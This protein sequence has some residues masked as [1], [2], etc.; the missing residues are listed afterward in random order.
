MEE[1]RQ[2]MLVYQQVGRGRSAHAE[3]A[4]RSVH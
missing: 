2:G 3:E 4:D 1:A